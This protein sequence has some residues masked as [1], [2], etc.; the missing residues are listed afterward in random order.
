MQNHINQ[1]L[2]S[3]NLVA[4]N[5]ERRI[6]KCLEFV[7]AQTYNNIEVLVFDNNSNDKT[8]EIV[9][10]EFAEHIKSGKLKIHKSKDNIGFGPGQNRAATLTRGKY[11]L[12]L[13]ADVW[14]REDFVQ[15]AVKAMEN[16][17]K[18]GALQAKIFRTIDGQKSDI[19]D[20]AGFEIYKSRRIVNRGHGIKDTGQ[21]DKAEEIF[22]YEGACP[23]WSR[24]AFQDC[25]IFGQT[26]DESYF[27]YGDDIDLGWRMH[28]L[29]WKNHYAP[30]V[31]AWHER[32]TTHRLS[33]SKFDFI[34]L[35]KELPKKK[36]MLDFV[37]VHLTLIKNDLG[38]FTWPD[39]YL[40]LKREILLLG[41]FLVF[42][43]Y[44][45]FVGIPRI[46]KSLPSAIRKRRQ[47]MQRK[48]VSK[49]EIK[50]WYL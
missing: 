4:Y 14:L 31:I 17:A 1:P 40:F 2:V 3:V 29:G 27:W 33:N 26:H 32:H 9:E 20:T 34:R 24:S 36:R 10:K 12:G 6:K 11:I 21:Y 16:D 15:E 38:L 50:K 39:I 13:C 37:N 35:R 49:E 22:S 44:T 28:L 48:K 18:I 42:E 7:F 30:S 43:P 46:A 45:I 47:I 5:E 41:Y 19:L 23:F 8:V 25:A